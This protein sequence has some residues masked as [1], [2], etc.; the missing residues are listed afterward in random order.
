M[1]DSNYVFNKIENLYKTDYYFLGQLK[2]IVESKGHE[3]I[4]DA[5]PYK[6]VVNK[7]D[8]SDEKVDGLL[9]VEDITNNEYDMLI[10]KQSESQ[11]TA[12]DKMKIKKH[13][14]KKCLGV[15]ILNQELIDN[16]DFSTI[17]KICRF[18]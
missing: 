14:F 6:P 9:L 2:Q 11:A 12:E 7:S 10:H 18:D 17:K 5:S 3:F 16:Y 13:V 8:D 15:D 1:Y 4:L